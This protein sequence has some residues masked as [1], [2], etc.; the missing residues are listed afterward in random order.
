MHTVCTL[1]EFT[2]ESMDVF[3]GAAPP[4]NR[5]R[6]VCSEYSL[7]STLD[8][9][10]AAEWRPNTATA[11]LSTCSGVKFPNVYRLLTIL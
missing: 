1:T 3:I 2:P 9:A 5:P 11:A 8:S 10:T 7:A 6:N 4:P